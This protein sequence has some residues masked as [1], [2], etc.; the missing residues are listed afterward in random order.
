MLDMSSTFAGNLTITG[1]VAN[2]VVVEKARTVTHI[3]FFEYREDWRARY[4]RNPCCE[5]VVV[6]IG[7]LLNR[8]A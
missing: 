4:Y 8:A 1:P 6:G 3:S 7:A 5:I 2:I